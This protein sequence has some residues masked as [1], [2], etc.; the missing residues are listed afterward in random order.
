MDFPQAPLKGEKSSKHRSF[1]I[2]PTEALF[3]GRKVGDS[4]LFFLFKN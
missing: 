2:E 4:A 3:E 1:E